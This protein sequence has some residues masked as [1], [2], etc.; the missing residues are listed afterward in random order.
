MLIILM[1]M[2]TR[3]SR[4][5]VSTAVRSFFLFIQRFVKPYLD[6]V[7]S[8]VIRRLMAPTAN[9]K[10]RSEKIKGGSCKVY[11][12]SIRYSIWVVFVS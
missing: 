3:N 6:E 4:L 7:S 8:A 9:N 10:L 11:L 5:A 1:I 2:V 12:S